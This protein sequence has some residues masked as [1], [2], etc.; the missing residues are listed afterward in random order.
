MLKR[1]SYPVLVIGAALVGAAVAVALSVF[2]VA[3]AAVDGA[4]GFCLALWLTAWS[5]FR[6]KA[7]ERKA[8]A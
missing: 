2:S 4:M 7:N 5:N 1:G 6:R 3:S 8:S